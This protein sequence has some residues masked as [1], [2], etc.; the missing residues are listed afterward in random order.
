VD[1][2]TGLIKSNLPSRISFHVFSKVDSRTILD[3]NGAEKLLGKGDM[4]FL[5]PGTSKLARVQGTFVSDNEIKNVVDYIKQIALPE[6]SPELKVWQGSL[7]RND[8]AAKDELY[9][10]AVRIVLETQRGSVSLLQRRLEIGY[11]RAARLIDLMAED[12]I[13]GEYKGSQAREVFV[14]LDEWE[15][16]NK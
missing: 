8:A 3:Q 10:E 5:P 6:F 12:G 4:L 1:V 7:K 9:E 16:Q 13:V 2:I 11:S 15:A 14:A